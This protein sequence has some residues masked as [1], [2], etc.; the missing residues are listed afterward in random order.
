[1]PPLVIEPPIWPIC[2]E[3]DGLLHCRVVPLCAWVTLLKLSVRYSVCAR[4]VTLAAPV[5][6]SML[7][8]PPAAMRA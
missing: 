8:S 2:V 1:M 6:P 3:I 5:I 4:L 7:K